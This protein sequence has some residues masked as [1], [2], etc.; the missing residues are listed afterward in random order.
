MYDQIKEKIE[1]QIIELKKSKLEDES[2]NN[3]LVLDFIK[4]AEELN[5]I[6]PNSKFNQN[7]K[8][9]ILDWDN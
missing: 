2:I 7:L 9:L 4:K 8:K 3:K 1:K 6:E 5:L